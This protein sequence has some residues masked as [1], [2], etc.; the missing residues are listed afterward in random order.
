LPAMA[1]AEG[2]TYV[3]PRQPAVARGV[4]LGDLTAGGEK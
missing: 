1:K 4:T 3:A 2:M